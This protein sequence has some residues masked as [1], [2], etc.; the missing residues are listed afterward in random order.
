[1]KNCATL[2]AR[3]DKCV[4][5]GAGVL[6]KKLPHAKSA[7]ANSTSHGT[8]RA[9]ID[10]GV[11][12]RMSAPRP[13]PTRLIANNLR[14]VSPVGVPASV[15]PVKPVTSCAG[16]SAT[17]E[18]MLAA[19]ASMPVSISDG[20]VM[21]EPPPASAFCTPAHIEAMKRMMRALIRRRFVVRALPRR[22]LRNQPAA[23]RGV[24]LFRSLCQWAAAVGGGRI[25]R[26]AGHG[27]EEIVI[28]PVAC[29]FRRLLDLEQ[30]EVRHHAA[31]GLHMPVR[32]EGVVDRQL[33]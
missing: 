13:P 7:V 31:I 5:P 16:N 27:C 24:R 15:R 28:I 3:G 18:V 19:R 20:R 1:M 25:G 33:L 21:N 32:S 2:A 22:E 9:E 11:A 30:I 29:A 14:I 26:L 6:R 23:R 10:G 17:V 8:R 4:S 12:R